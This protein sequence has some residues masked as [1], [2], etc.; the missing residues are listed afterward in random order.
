MLSVRQNDRLFIIFS[1]YYFIPQ[2]KVFYTRT[3]HVFAIAQIPVGTSIRIVQGMLMANCSDA[4]TLYANG[5]YGEN[6]YLYYVKDGVSTSAVNISNPVT[7]NKSYD[8]LVVVYSTSNYC[9]ISFVR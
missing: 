8:I 9:D 2:N 5:Y 1:K 7:I 6:G 3:T 4:T